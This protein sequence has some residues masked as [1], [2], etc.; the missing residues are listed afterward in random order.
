MAVLIT[1][2][3]GH[4]GPHLVAELLRAGHFHRMYV[5]ARPTDVSAVVRV[6]AVERTARSLIASN[7]AN[8][9]L[10]VVPIAADLTRPGDLNAA[11]RTAARDVTVIVHAA[12]DT[13]FG[14]RIDTLRQVNVNATASVCE[15]AACCTRLRQLLF[16]STAC[17]AGRRSGSIPEALL[18][19][20]A[21]FA[22]A[23][24]Q[25]KW[26]AEQL[27]AL[28]GLPVRIARLSTCAGSHVTGFVHRFGA[29]HH[30]CHWM[31]RGLVP[32]VPGGASTPIDVISTDV[33][34]A[35]L[36]RAAERDPRQLEICHVALGCEAVPLA[37]LLDFLATLLR[38]D[39]GSRAQ[40]PM[41]VDTATF[42]SFNRMVRVSGDALMAR[43]QT[44]AAAMLPSLLYPKQFETECAEL[45]WG[46]ALPHAD[47]RALLSKVIAFARTHQY[48]LRPAV[49][50]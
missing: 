13:R 21:G 27:V 1:G 2:A 25:T 39:G 17:V 34:A 18:D 45:C 12:A 48:G 15:L 3:T 46:G 7:V 10:E 49:E 22:N 23:Y 44:S 33:A 29:L 37:A 40:R 26:E 14:A 47:W 35:W 11:A 20:S 32:L 8:R 28:S 36:A 5:I 31:S 19:D 30:L 50:A 38:D 4:L 24:E 6:K 41:L 16:V 43:V 9:H 42:E